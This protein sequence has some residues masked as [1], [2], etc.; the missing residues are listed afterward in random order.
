M[1]EFIVLGHVPGTQFQITF[2]EI[3]L[4]SLLFFG[5]FL[6]NY[7]LSKLTQKLRATQPEIEETAL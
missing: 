5:S 6:L 2:T 1:L 7:D 4:F 3:A